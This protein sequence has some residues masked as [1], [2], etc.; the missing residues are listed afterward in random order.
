MSTS[1]PP[2]VTNTTYIG[3]DNTTV[4]N[5]I[6]P[7]K[8]GDSPIPSEINYFVTAAP[9]N[10]DAMRACCEPNAVQ[11]V[12]TCFVWCELP[13]PFLKTSEFNPPPAEIT[14][15][16]KRSVDKLFRNCLESRVAW[17]NTT[18]YAYLH[19]VTTADPAKQP[20]G[21]GAAGKA[22]GLW[23]LALLGGL[24]YLVL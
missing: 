18:G 22:V 11:V 9:P 17:R 10:D 21:N 7:T 15:E 3:G 8:P 23:R 24:L 6:Q 14:D 13:R 16:Y 19:L 4:C 12:D 2:A 1:P 20:H 5:R